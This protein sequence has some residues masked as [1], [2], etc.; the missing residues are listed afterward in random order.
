MATLRVLLVALSVAL[1]LTGPA[2]ILTI[3]IT[4]STP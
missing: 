2:L 4:R 1:V 3:A